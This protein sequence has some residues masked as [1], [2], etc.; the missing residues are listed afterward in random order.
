MN[1][2]KKKVFVKNRDMAF[3]LASGSP[4]K[5]KKT[6]Y[7]CCSVCDDA[8]AQVEGYIINLPWK[9][10]P[11]KLKKKGFMV[12]SIRN[13]S[14]IEPKYV[15]RGFSP[16]AYFGEIDVYRWFDENGDYLFYWESGVVE[17]EIVWGERQLIAQ[18][19]MTMYHQLINY[20]F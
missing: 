16:H 15:M 1:T 4:L 9:E 20:N 11:R 7:H 14:G 5:V 19:D 2:S 10:T 13:T 17:N 8:Y 18:G 3:K 6:Y 12:S